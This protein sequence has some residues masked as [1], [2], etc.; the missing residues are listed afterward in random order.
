MA[1]IGNS[2]NLFAGADLTVQRLGNV[3][4]R[5]H[6]LRRGNSGGLQNVIAENKV[7]VKYI[8]NSK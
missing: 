8:P 4:L 6:L 1:N 2:T 5:L 7:V 3:Q